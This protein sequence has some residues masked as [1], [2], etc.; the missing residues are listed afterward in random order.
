[1]SDLWLGSIIAR[2]RYSHFSRSYWFL[3]Q[4]SVL[5]AGSVQDLQ[6][7]WRRIQAP[8]LHHHFW[9]LP[10]SHVA[11]ARFALPQISELRLQRLHPHLLCNSCGHVH[12][13]R[14]ATHPSAS[15]PCIPYSASHKHP[16]IC[17]IHSPALC[18]HDGRLMQV[19][20]ATRC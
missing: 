8:L 18:T 10:V 13:H 19:H 3:I 16:Y 9:L 4:I 14:F 20:P 5:D 6:P 7:R 12:S 2:K 17:A 11:A 1:M 15:T